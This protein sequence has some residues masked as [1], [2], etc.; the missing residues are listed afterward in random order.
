[1]RKPLVSIISVNY[2]QAAV[3]CA[4]LASLARIS[5]PHV[6]IIV[7]DNASPTD[8]PGPIARLF[9]RVQLIRATENLGFAGGNNLGLHRATGEY[10]LFLNNDTEVAPDFLEPLV[11]LFEADPTAGIASAKLLFFGTPGPLIQYAGST[12]LNPWTGRNRSLGA[13][14]P[15][16][17]QHDRT[18]R[19]GL[20]HGAAMMVP[21]RVIRQVGLMPAIYFLYYEELDWGEMIKRAGYGCYYVGQS[22]VWHKESV[23][24]GRSSVLKTYYLHRNRMVFIRRNLTGL[25]GWCAL[26]FFLLVAAPKQVLVHLLRGELGHVGAVGRAIAWHLR[27]RPVRHNDFLPTPAP[28]SAPV[29]SPALAAAR[30]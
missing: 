15:D 26:G 30:P 2:N 21:L 27:P 14:E 5:Y 23:S 6:E 22:T 24:V 13:H 20:P 9:P 19:T 4:M 10:V 1:M 16:R 28:V 29:G 11:A 12:P 3:T 25:Q 8:D 18:R 7:V 17:G